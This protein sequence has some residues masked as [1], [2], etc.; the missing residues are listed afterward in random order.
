MDIEFDKRL[1]M[2][3][4]ALFFN[5]LLKKGQWSGITQMQY[6]QWN[7]NFGQ[8]EEGKYIASRILN[9]LL[10]YSENDILKM[11]ECAFESIFNREVILPL[12]KETFFSRLPSELEYE[13]NQAVSKSIV[14]PLLEEFAN[15]GASGPEIARYIQSH[16]R[17]RFQM[18]YHFDIVPNSQYDRIIIVDDCI[19]SGD[20]LKDFW[21]EA[22]IKNNTLLKDWAA[23]NT[24]KIYYVSL[25]GYR[26]TIEEL[27]RKIKEIE[28]VCI[29]YIDN[30]HQ[31]FAEESK[32]WLD[33]E[34]KNWAKMQLETRIKD[35]GIS[36]NGYSN[37]SFAVVL[38]KTIPDWTL[39]ALYKNRN[40]W[41]HLIERKDTY[42]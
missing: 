36:V 23:K 35:I 7:N 4:S 26:R 18:A 28:I 21:N 10:Y 31:I 40:G 42:D 29:D 12:Q 27:K 1:Y 3:Q 24:N 13:I 15:P 22:R 30:N 39:P 32:C 20:Q 37:L 19:G 17:P 38:H 8:V 16:I 25:V 14:I 33:E 34:E 41:S 6:H 9:S 11:L 5:F 2:D